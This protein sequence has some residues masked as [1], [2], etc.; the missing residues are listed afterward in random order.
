[1]SDALAENMRLLNDA[2]LAATACQWCHQFG[3][4]VKDCSHHHRAWIQLA[5]QPIG[6]TRW[7]Q[8]LAGF[9]W[10][11]FGFVVGVLVGKGCGV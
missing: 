10:M 4:E 7:E 3:H 11:A 9:W 6:A 2:N 1:M 8:F 5:R